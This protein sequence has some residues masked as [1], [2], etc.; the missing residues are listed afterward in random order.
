M[1]PLRHMPGIPPLPAPAAA[2]DA[3]RAPAA[4]TALLDWAGTVSVVPADDLYVVLYERLHGGDD[5]HLDSLLNAHTHACMARRHGLPHRCRA[6]NV[7]RR[8]ASRSGKPVAV[9]RISSQAAFLLKLSP[10]RSI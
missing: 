1:R 3:V 8:I 9:C 10:P 7:R 4:T 2:R 6:S 5:L